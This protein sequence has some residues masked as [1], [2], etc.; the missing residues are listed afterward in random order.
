MSHASRT[1]GFGFQCLLAAAGLASSGAALGNSGS[2]DF[3]TGNVTAQA[4]GSP[5]RAL[6]KGA[7]VRSGDT[8]RTNDGM[9][10][11][12]YPDGA[13]VSLRPDTEYT[14]ENY[15]FEG[16]ADGSEQGL[17]KLIK[18]TMRT[19]TGLV[20]RIN[21][22]NYRISTP[23]ATIGI[24][25]TG[26][27]I[28][29]NS[30]TGATTVIGT[31]GTWDLK[32][33]TGSPVPVGAGQTGRTTSSPTQPAEQVSSDPG[34][35][36][37][38]RAAQ[39]STTTTKT[40]YSSSEDRT[41]SGTATAVASAKTYSAI[42]LAVIGTSSVAF[43]TQHAA[44]PGSVDVK[45]TVDSSGALTGFEKTGSSFSEKVAVSGGTLT[46]HGTEGPFIWGRIINA[47][48]TSV[49]TSSS[50]STSVYS[51][52]PNGGISFAAG[53]A[54]TDMPK[55]GTFTYALVPGAVTRPSFKSEAAIIG[56]VTAGQLTGTFTSTGGS[57]AANMSLNINSQA[58]TFT[59]S[60]SIFNSGFSTSGSTTG[61][62]CSTSCS[63]FLNGSFAG[64]GAS[65]ASGAYQITLPGDALNGV[66][67]FKK[68]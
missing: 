66:A 24:R 56:G 33:Q 61:G 40:E 47:T 45:V 58:Y 5:P 19:V 2:I 34:S 68:Q 42:S 41:S 51:V 32:A 17:F 10:Q 37:T 36:R 52:G 27:V 48:L 23:T 65:H 63:S 28:A 38:T 54:T 15:R 4:L 25:G 1:G 21:R 59:T 64:S 30:A 6:A 31:S 35:S 49:V 26:G 14:I 3:V 29:V 62:A 12:R 55:S 67:I 7:E 20:G 22:A 43:A 13:Y 50:T 16:K 57:I 53:D 11:I 44:V 60:G 46:E 9:V 39:Q 8:V 18:G